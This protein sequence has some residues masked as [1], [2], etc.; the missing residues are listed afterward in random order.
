MKSVILMIAR[1]VLW[2]PKRLKSKKVFRQISKVGLHDFLKKPKYAH[3]FLADFRSR[4]EPP[5]YFNESDTEFFKIAD[6]SS[7][8]KIV[9][10]ADAICEHN[11][12]LLG[13]G[14]TNISG[15]DGKIDWHRDFKSGMSWNANVFFTK[16]TF[17]KGDGSDIM[18]PWELSR[19]QHLPTLGK[20]YLLTGNEKYA[21]EFVDEIDGW[22]ESNPAEYGVNWAS[23]MDVAIR[24][25]NWIWGYY[26][27]KG[28]YQINDGFLL[29]FLGSLFIHG[30]HI[31]ANLARE[32]RVVDFFK[33]LL[34]NDMSISSSLRQ[35]KIA[36]T[37]NHYLSNVVGLVYLGIMLPEFKE[38][39]KWQEFGIRELIR[40][41]GKQVYPDGAA[42][43]SSISYHHLQTE[44][45][46]SSTLLCLKNGIT[47]PHWYMKRLEQ[48]LEFVMYYT[49]PEGTAPQIGDNDDGRLHILAD[50]GD[51]DKRDHRHL[52][53][54]G[55]T[56]FDRADFKSAAGFY[57]E[58]FWLLGE[59]GLIKWN[60]L[61]DEKVDLSS[62]A[63]G[64][65]GF[66]ILRKD[67]L[68]LMVDC[69]LNDLS[70]S[71][72]HRHNSRLSFDLFA[73]DKSFIIDPG[74]YV[75]TADKD[76]RN[77]FRSTGYHNTVIVDG[78]EQNNF[79]ADNLFFMS[80]NA[81]VKINQW[82][83]TEEYDFLDAEHN[84]YRK[85][86]HPV[87][88]RRQ[89]W[90]DK[91]NGFWIVKDMLTSKGNHQFDLYFHFAPMEIEFDQGRALTVKTKGEG[92]NIAIIPLEE[93]GLS[94]EIV[95]GWVSYSYGV[96]Q[97][98][99]ILKYSKNSSSAI[100]CNILYPYE[101]AISVDGIM[102]ELQKSRLLSDVG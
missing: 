42:Y 17:I 51:W 98:A 45:F 39:K 38:A 35:S 7:R 53:S 25:V 57:E 93:E 10:D 16:T 23:T 55:A 28:C 83:V 33:N 69:L 8:Q 22:I 79:A 3:T 68:Y 48:M 86:K 44:L 60:S 90:F 72:V 2:Y 71:S 43:E 94:A 1:M 9:E 66:Y 32:S 63:F 12:N 91:V 61:A 89:I 4:K 46:L 21:Q 67:R 56:L 30:K 36:I 6:F 62:K 5:F 78:V 82:E 101:R 97:Q 58:T 65:S 85:L 50:Y 80:Y 92:A 87:I 18:V 76:M 81:D 14:K 49:K 75:Y 102:A 37:N 29:K 31:M 27:F 40:E 52:L 15:K 24:A 64:S 88:H 77:L 20:A 54:T 34:I 95:D 59:D 99:P 70:V 26:F 73:Y 74:A 84:G 19:F 47:F 41:M 11:F 100:F 96:K 13:S